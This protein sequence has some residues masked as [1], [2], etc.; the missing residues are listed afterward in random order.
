[1]KCKA[2]GRNISGRRWEEK[3]KGENLLCIQVGH[4]EEGKTW[5]KELT[6]FGDLNVHTVGL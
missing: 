3:G 1:M 5:G 2:R 4:G 6:K